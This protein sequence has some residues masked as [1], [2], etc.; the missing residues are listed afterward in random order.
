MLLGDHS[1]HSLIEQ[2]E[3]RRTEN[4]SSPHMRQL[5]NP[6]LLAPP[7]CQT[8]PSRTELSPSSVLIFQ[9]D[10]STAMHWVLCLMESFIQA[11]LSPSNSMTP[12]PDS[13]PLL[14]LVPL[15]RMLLS[16]AQR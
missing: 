4:S 8:Q 5:Q 12:S 10:W 3:T 7:P 6:R 16:F 2:M 11:F 14:L 1:H 13:K 15:L 9:P